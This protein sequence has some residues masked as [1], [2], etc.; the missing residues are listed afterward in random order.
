[1]AS[2]TYISMYLVSRSR[3]ILISIIAR[4]GGSKFLALL[5]ST[6]EALNSHGLNHGSMGLGCS[7]P[8]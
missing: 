8:G 3:V 2:K 4:N 5:E 1:M 6:P 7:M